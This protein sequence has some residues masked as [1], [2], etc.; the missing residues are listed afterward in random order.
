MKAHEVCSTAPSY[1]F[2]NFA[3]CQVLEAETWESQSTFATFY[4]R[5]GICKS[6]DTVSFGP[7]VVTW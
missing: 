6:M 2:Q 4:L 5:D 1:M 7:V 3:I